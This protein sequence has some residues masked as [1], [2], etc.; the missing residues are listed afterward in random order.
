VRRALPLLAALALLAL[1][2]SVPAGATEAPSP[3]T[4]EDVVRM[5]SQ[6]RPEA[7]ILRIIAASAVDF[8]LDPDMRE[9]LRR[10]GVT[11][12][13]LGAMR[14]RQAVA[15]IR[16]PEI[17]AP[18]PGEVPSGELLVSFA[19]MDE[20]DAKKGASFQM[21]RKVPQWAIRELGMDE[22]AE[23]EELALFVACTTP[24][25]VP[26]HWQDRTKLKEFSRHRMLAFR[27]GSH[28][29]KE[30]KFEM[31]SLDIPE[32]LTIQ[33]P[34]GRHRLSVGVAAKVG[35]DW[36]AI[37][38]DQRDGVSIQEGGT[39][40]LLVKIQGQWTGSRMRGFQADQKLI[41]EEVR[42]PGEPS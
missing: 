25:H 42:S 34:A 8:E 17:P 38:S 31:L 41:I 3:L 30:K 28:P 33:V 26:D 24:A 5:V 6:G 15:G 29:G 10:A 1:P 20:K 9:E 13:I 12:K 40:R 14:E 7:E 32:S 16:R 11:E 19:P 23:V 37:V 21:V 18:T 36:R 35:P 22:K 4:N 27:P 2:A 39:T